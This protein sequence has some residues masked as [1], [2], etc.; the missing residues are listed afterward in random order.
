MS[1]RNHRIA[2]GVTRDREMVQ[3]FFPVMSRIRVVSVSIALAAATLTLAVYAQ[4]PSG[5]AAT[6][7]FVGATVFDGTGNQPIRNAA[8]VVRNQRIVAVGPANA[9]A[10]PPRAR[11]IDLA[12]RT[13]VPGLVNA[14]GHV[15]STAGLESGPQFNT[16]ANVARQLALY[17]RYGVTTVVSLGDDGPAGFSARAGNSSA[18]IRRAR[19]HVA[20]PV[21]SAKTPQEARKAVDS[22]A[23]LKPNWIK[24]RVD[25]NLGTTAKMPPDVYRAVIEQA[26]KRDLRVAAHMF[27]LADAKE[28]LRAG[29][30]F[31]A[32]SVRDTDV[33]T[34]FIDLIKKRNVC[35]APTLMREVSTFIYESRPPFFDDPFFRRHADARVVATLEDRS[36]QSDVAASKSAQAYKK[37]LEVARR[38]VKAL[39]DAGVPIAFGTDTGPPARFQG[40][41]EH[42]ELEELVRAGLTP[43]E[44]MLSAT[45]D[46]AA[47]MGLADRVG[48]LQPGRFADFVVLS[49][50]PLDDIRQSK[51]IESVWVS[52]NKVQ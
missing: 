52:G 48:T 6:T 41:F 47:C 18:S 33:D 1:P 16:P 39:R 36:R 35:V 29:V 27:Y 21:I 37:A 10:M 5:S 42:L 43:F 46:A 49:R 15:G 7:V 34:E 38:N 31:L 23:A 4:A 17:A 13:I 44:A 25:D 51:T 28:L 30:D 24:I 14:H 20:G 26:H 19:L 40:Y 9:V 2:A 12:G 3:V 22:A 11:R 50:S 45:R 8:I 32:H